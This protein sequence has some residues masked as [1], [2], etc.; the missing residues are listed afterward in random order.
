MLT[1]SGG[2]DRVLVNYSG[3]HVQSESLW[4]IGSVW[5]IKS[6]VHSSLKCYTVGGATVNIAEQC[7][8]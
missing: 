8:H 2:E 4:G 5:Y 7:I 1:W 6:W 3:A